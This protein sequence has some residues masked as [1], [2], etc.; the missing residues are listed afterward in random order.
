MANNLV[1]L[2]HNANRILY[3]RNLPHNIDGQDLYDL[4]GKYGP[5]RQIRLGNVP[6]TITTAYVVYDDVYDAEK[7][8]SSLNG[9]SMSGRFLIVQFFKIRPKS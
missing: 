4:F 2:A 8:K 1:S 9:Y 5:I 3:V 6:A 7:A